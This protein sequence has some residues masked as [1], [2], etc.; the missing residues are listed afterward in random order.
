[1]AVRGWARA[2]LSRLLP[3]RPP[4]PAIRGCFAQRGGGARAEL[5]RCADALGRVA[6]ERAWSVV[7]SERRLREGSIYSAPL[8]S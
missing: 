5:S 3:L 4:Q 6:R 7:V 1:M 2:Q 8:R